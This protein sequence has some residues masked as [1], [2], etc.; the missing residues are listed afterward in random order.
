M[1][2][3]FC[4]SFGFSAVRRIASLLD[5]EKRCKMSIWLQKSASIQPRTSLP[6][7]HE[8]SEFHREFHIR[9]P[10]QK[11]LIQIKKTDSDLFQKTQCQCGIRSKRSWQFISQKAPNVGGRSA[12][13]HPQRRNGH[14]TCTTDIDTAK[15]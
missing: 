12:Q 1:L 4:E 10:P 6:K 15:I 11:K 13:A 9:I 3:R 2:T 7:F 5:L 14:S 8:G